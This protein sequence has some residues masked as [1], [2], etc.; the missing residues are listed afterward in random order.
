MVLKSQPLK[1]PTWV[2]D[3]CYVRKYG[4]VCTDVLNII[5][6]MGTAWVPILRQ[7]GEY[8]V[9]LICWT[10]SSPL[11]SFYNMQKDRP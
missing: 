6:S 11:S 5:M 7:Q 8:I 1:G 4:S 9:M 3:D 10:S 2:Q